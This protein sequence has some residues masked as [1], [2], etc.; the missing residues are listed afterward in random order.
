M[1]N[2]RAVT[3]ESANPSCLHIIRENKLQ[4][5]ALTTVVAIGIL[6]TVGLFTIANLPIV[7]YPMHKTIAWVTGSLS[8]NIALIALF[9]LTRLTARKDATTDTSDLLDHA[10]PV[11]CR[12]PSPITPSPSPSHALEHAN[13]SANPDEMLFSISQRSPSPR[14]DTH[15]E[16]SS[17]TERRELTNIT[18]RTLHPASTTPTARNTALQQSRQDPSTMHLNLQAILTSISPARTVA[19]AAPPTARETGELASTA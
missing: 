5:V 3:Q 18:D 12:P 4:V 16:S 6:A 11:P 14:R 1:S 9:G 19:A 10:P 15:Q 8:S 13:T 17:D 2:V 7:P